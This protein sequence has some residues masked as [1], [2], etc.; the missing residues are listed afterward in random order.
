LADAAKHSLTGDLE[1]F[2]DVRFATSQR[3]TKATK[4][5][6]ERGERGTDIVGQ[7]ARSRPTF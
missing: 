6:N 5:W 4:P 7:P 1:Q 3:Q 2:V